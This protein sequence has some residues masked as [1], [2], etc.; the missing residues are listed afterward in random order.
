MGDQAQ[1][2]VKADESDR[3]VYLYTHWRGDEIVDVLRAALLRGATRWEDPEYLARII[4]CQMILD[5][6]GTVDP[7]N[8]TTG[9]GIGAKQHVTLDHPL[10]TVNCETQTISIGEDNPVSFEDFVKDH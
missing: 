9:F 2:V 5:P 7:I 6:S 3:G 8:D 10:I 1:I 4:F